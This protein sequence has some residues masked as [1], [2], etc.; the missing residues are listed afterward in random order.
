DPAPLAS[1]L[2]GD[3]VNLLMS[4]GASVI[5]RVP[6]FVGMNVDDARAVA[7]RSNIKLGQ[8]VWTPL[9]ANGPRHGVVAKQSIPEGS[10]INSY[11]TVSLDVSAGPNESGYLVRQ[12]RVLASVPVGDSSKPGQPVKVVLR[13]RDATGQYDAYRAYAQEGQ[14]ID[15]VVTAIGTSVVDFLANDVLVGESR[16]GNEPVHLYNDGKPEPAASPGAPR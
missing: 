11:E 5:A 13:V 16:L 2:E 7:E 1:V 15:F 6:N 3:K 4:R 9:G 8:V 12:V 10:K 14:K